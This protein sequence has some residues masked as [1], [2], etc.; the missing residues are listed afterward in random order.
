[1]RRA[2]PYREKKEIVD[3]H[4]ITVKDWEDMKETPVIIIKNNTGR[5]Y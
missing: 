4:G 1:L 2:S 5:G 3:K